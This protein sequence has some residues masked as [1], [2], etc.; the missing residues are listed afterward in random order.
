MQTSSKFEAA[1]LSH[2]HCS[3]SKVEGIAPA[4]SEM[5]EFD[6]L[7]VSSENYHYYQETHDLVGRAEGF[8]RLEYSHTQFPPFRIIIEDRI[9]I[10]AK[11]STGCNK[12]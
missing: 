10:L 12:D 2:S 1:T 3:Y 7:L 4:S 8:V 11:K 5:L 9:L 6:F